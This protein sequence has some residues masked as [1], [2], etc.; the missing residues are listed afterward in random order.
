MYVYFSDPRRGHFGKVTTGATLCEA[1]SNVLDWARM[2]TGR[3]R[4]GPDTVLD[5]TLVSDDRKWRVSV[6]RVIEW[7]SRRDLGGSGNS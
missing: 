1:A 3:D 7:C 2:L 4:P 6:Y 5:M